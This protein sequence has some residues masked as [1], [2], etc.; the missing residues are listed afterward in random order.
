MPTITT[1]RYLK[2]SKIVFTDADEQIHP[3]L[4]PEHLSRKRK[5]NPYK[6]KRNAQKKL[7]LA[8]CEYETRSGKKVRPRAVKEINC[9]CHYKCAS[10]FKMQQRE[11]MLADYLTLDSERDRWSFIG[12]RVKC[13]P[14]K[15]RYMGDGNRRKHT[16]KYT[17]AFNEE[18][19]Q[20]CKRFFLGTHDISE[21][22]VRKR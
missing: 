5:R 13:V 9:K 22:K 19:H 17:M 21:K 15:R 11:Q 2:V 7:R 1:F 18:E 14:V 4:S 6:W 12:K 20:V 3:D 10:K 8:G 16:L